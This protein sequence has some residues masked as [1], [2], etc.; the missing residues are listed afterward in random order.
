MTTQRELNMFNKAIRGVFNLDGDVEWLVDHNYIEEYG[1]PVSN[2]M[3]YRVLKP[4]RFDHFTRE[5]EVGNTFKIG[6][7][8]ES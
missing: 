2:V 3:Y 7:F 5:Y 1:S 8:Y 6:D 4:F